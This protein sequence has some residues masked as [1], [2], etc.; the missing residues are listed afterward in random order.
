MRGPVRMPMQSLQ[1]PSHRP[2]SWNWIWDWLDGCEPKL[3]V[4]IA[5]HDTPTIRPF[6]VGIL[7][8]VAPGRIGF[9]NI[10][11]YS[12]NWNAL[13]ILDGTNYETLLALSVMRDASPVSNIFRLMGMK[14]AKD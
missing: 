12:F 1:E 10:D 4:L 6:P 13:G 2:V 11:F 8:I 9:P 14:R 3:P 5:T 7:Q